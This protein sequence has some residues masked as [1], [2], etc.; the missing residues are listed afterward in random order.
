MLKSNWSNGLIKLRVFFKSR[1]SWLHHVFQIFSVISHSLSQ[2]VSF[3]QLECVFWILYVNDLYFL[4]LVG[5]PYFS[6]EFITLNEQIRLKILLTPIYSRLE[7]PITE[8]GRNWA[9]S[10]SLPSASV[11]MTEATPLKINIIG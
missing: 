9:I 10:C 8:P 5:S 2:K 6:K 1:K 3:E 11:K 4:I 7:I